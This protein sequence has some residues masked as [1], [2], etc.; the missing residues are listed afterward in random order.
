MAD[1]FFIVLSN[2]IYLAVAIVLI[3]R[4]KQVYDNYHTWHFE[5]FIALSVG[6]ISSMYHLC[7]TEADCIE[8]YSFMIDSDY[9]FSMLI[10]NIGFTVHLG[11]ALAGIY[12]VFINFLTLVLAFFYL[13]DTYRT[14]MPIIIINAIT[15]LVYNY[16]EW[17][18]VKE[19]RILRF[20]YVSLAITFAVIGYV[21]KIEGDNQYYDTYHPIWHICTGFAFIFSTLAVIPTTSAAADVKYTKLS[22][23]KDIL[24][25]LSY[26]LPN[27]NKP[28][29]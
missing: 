5:I 13:V 9:L 8:N 23:D 19:N 22:Q 11:I 7:D 2:I 4:S 25:S 16:H 29:D 17:F 28:I 24:T 10:L 21:M 18:F 12:K 15:V 6:F 20:I 27:Y 26:F 14:V 1:W 3:I